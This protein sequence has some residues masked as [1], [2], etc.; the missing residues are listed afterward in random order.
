[1]KLLEYIEEKPRQ[2]RNIANVF[3]LQKISEEMSR[4]NLDATFSAPRFYNDALWVMYLTCPYYGRSH[5][6]LHTPSPTK[7]ALFVNYENNTAFAMPRKG[8]DKQTQLLITSICNKHI[9]DPFVFDSDIR[10]ELFQQEAN[11]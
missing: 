9:N 2:H 6:I 4:Y 1:M 5:N 7:V 3:D 10:Y 11:K 8:A